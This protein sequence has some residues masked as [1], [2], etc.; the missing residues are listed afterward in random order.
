MLSST[1][2]NLMLVAVMLGHLWI[3]P[4]TKVEESFNLQ[5]IHDI[6]HHKA[7]ISLYD[8]LEF[9]GVVPRTF[10]GPL[11]VA[12]IAYPIAEVLHYSHVSKFYVQ[13]LSRAIL[14]L[15]V[16][17]AFI[18]LQRSVSNRANPS[19]GKLMTILMVSQFHF[20]FY[21]SRTLPNTFAL[22]LVVL[23]ISC[24]IRNQNKSFIWYSAF[25]IIIFR[26]E[27][28]IFMGLLLII[29]LIN[30]QIC[31]TE[32]LIQGSMAGTIALGSTVLVDSYFWQRWVWPEGEVL[33]YNTVLNK[34]SNWGTLPFF[35]Y[36]YSAIPRCMSFS[37]LFVPIGMC[38]SQYRELRMLFVATILYILIYSIL[39]HKELRF[40]IYVFPVLNIAASIGITRSL[41]AFKSYDKLTRLFKLFAVGAVFASLCTTS[42]LS[43]ISSRN[44]P[45]GEA[46]S[47]LHRLNH[48]TKQEHKAVHICNKA[49][50]SGVSRF[51]ELY[52]NWTYS[53]DESFKLTRQVYSYDH[54]IVEAPCPALDQYVIQV[55]VKGFSRLHIKKSI[56]FLEIIEEEQLCVLKLKT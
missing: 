25:A 42:L 47:L 16:C 32:L 5:A 20:L 38:S 29:K 18:K 14:G 45:G 4:Y 23:A 17:V 6:L 15:L 52:S 2:L 26:S 55:S 48:P 56:P 19:I 3:C 22:I 24:W 44:Y 54:L 35:W 9:P 12:S 33:F 7:D 34:S 13:I 11:V 8:H 27:L 36:F 49:A 30:K 28:C 39:P 46:F 31:V 10:L 1:I 51:G 43:A 21:S 53:K 37:L 41:H 40:I 50:Q